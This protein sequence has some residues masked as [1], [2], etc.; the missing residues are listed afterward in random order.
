M[1]NF[2]VI[3]DGKEYW[4]SRSVATATSI[5]TINDD[6]KLCVLANK[7]GTGLPGQNFSNPGKWSVIT[8]FLDY[9]ENFVQCC[10]REVHEETGVDISKVDLNFREFEDDP[11]R[12]GQVILMRYSGF[13][14]NGTELELTDKF[15]DPNEVAEIK[16][17]PLDELENYEWTS[18]RHIQKI[19]EYGEY[20][21]VE[22]RYE[23]AP[24]FEVW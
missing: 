18:E 9:N 11:S 10:I 22:N 12:D 7:R 14:E 8:G 1:N 24:D 15:S 5:F 20:E 13:I 16:W 19:R 4:I 2:P 3:V 17:I 21:C 6:N 23:L